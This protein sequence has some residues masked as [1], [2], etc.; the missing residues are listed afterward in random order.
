MGISTLLL[1]AAMAAASTT[2]PVQAPL[3]ATPQFRHYDI[4][5]G[6]PSSNVYTVVQDR[7]GAIWLGTRAGLARYDGTSFKVYRHIPGDATSLASDD[8]SS[9]LADSHGRLWAGGEGSGVNLLDPL[10]GTFRHFK[11]RA[12]DP[13]SLANNDVLTMAEGRNGTL[14]VGMYGAGLDH[15]ISPGHFVHLRHVKDDPSSLS[16]DVVLSLFSRGKG[17]VWIGTMRGM[18]I[19]DADGRLRH[20]RF[21]GLTK[22]PRVWRID[23]NA[24][25]VRADTTA[26]LFLV[27]DDAVARRID[28]GKLHPRGVFASARDRHGNLWLGT[29][30]G[31]Y[32]LEPDGRLKH[33]PARPLLP[34]GQPGQ[35]IW[36][37]TVDHEGGMWVA[38]QNSGVAYLSPDW[39]Q[40]AHYS[41]RPDDDS[42]LSASRILALAK[43]RDGELWVGGINGQLDKLDPATGKV[44]HE[45]AA[46]GLAPAS[47]T[48]LANTDR[49]G[50]WVGFHG[51]L[52]LFDGQRFRKVEDTRLG[53]GARWMATDASGTAYVSPPGQGVL[54]VDPDTLKVTPLIPGFAG[55]PGRETNALA[56]HDGTLWRASQA[57]LSRLAADGLHLT[58]V[59]GVARGP[60]VALGFAGHDLW[61]ARPHELDHYRLDEGKSTL[62]Q[63][64]D[65]SHGWPGLETNAL[66]VDGRGRV[67]LFAAAGLWRYSPTTRSFHHFSKADGL[68]SPEFTSNELVRLTNGTVYAG[69]LGGVIGFRPG[70][71]HDHPRPPRLV[72]TSALVRRD[73]HDVRLSLDSHRL[74]L[75]WDDRDLRITAHA[76]SYINPKL[77]H[78]R[79]R[80]T[81]F[82]PGWVDTGTRGVREL[83]GLKAGNYRLLVQAAGPSGAWGQLT[84][85][86]T[87]EVDAPP[88]LRPWAWLVYALVLALL[89][90]LIASIWRR[91]VE[92]RHRVQLA[93]Q[94][95]HMAEQ[96]NAAKTRF[97]ATLSH[98]IRTPMTGVLGMADLLLDA[99]LAARERGHV[100]TI[101]RS[102]R[103][104]LKLVNEAL[105]MARIEAGRLVLEPAPMDPR[106][107]IEEVR[108]LQTGQIRDK[109]L[110]VL[111]HVDADVPARLEGD[112]TRIKQILLNLTNNAIKFT[113][114]GSV[115]VTATYI[116]GELQ[117][118]VS[119]TGPG[120]SEADRQRLFQRFEQADSPQRKEGSGLGLAICH[121]LVGLM[122]GRI[123]LET[124]LGEGSCFK[125]F[126][127][128]REAPAE[129]PAAVP[130]APE[131]HSANA[132]RRLLL[133]E[134]DATVAQ[135]IVGLLE[136]R[137][138]RVTHAAHGLDALSEMQNRPFD[139]LLLDMNLPGM[140]GCQLTRM[141]RE[142]EG[143]NAHLPIIAITARSGGDEERQARAAG[144]DAFLRKPIDA[145]ELAR[146]LNRLCQTRQASPA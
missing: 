131:G 51:G 35:L 125:V 130:E 47:I 109:D 117:L 6:L 13:D 104:L 92:Q 115:A 25:E 1:A 81:G 46:L 75:R 137:G 30:H 116:Q 107:L 108:Q 17:R 26:G 21:E 76:M 79:F 78:Y 55:E 126:L 32:L 28:G 123:E 141:I 103:M 95:Q 145:E 96:A 72:L 134:D 82:D 68:P 37:L 18:D 114:H 14:W 127:P 98:E 85:P 41:H 89:I 8:V 88:W 42:S 83:A 27:G 54:R 93:H 143:N 60:V 87:I 133:I 97:L 146:T 144:M 56:M 29:T 74:H 101:R 34:G 86:L 140:D 90:Y 22:P 94:Q 66:T 73:G 122:G 53:S 64:I 15:M 23:G 33:F 120:I 113:P 44:T 11:H 4:N 58:P 59:P 102:G 43:G 2:S 12:D 100:E 48:A 24:H 49:H 99:N 119:D 132:S 110:D 91:R 36:Q 7:R 112:A 62:I 39:R 111:T 52:G 121:E 138:H 57:G 45:A 128:L 80:L 31:L 129:T 67:W 118:H 61:L 124:R 20:V 9:V 63:S 16:S 106:A 65:A 40:F 10:H 70:E 5:Q 50:L 136:A 69:S 3:P 19:R 135:V 71:E 139:A 142:R 77:N 105:D 84:T 38:T